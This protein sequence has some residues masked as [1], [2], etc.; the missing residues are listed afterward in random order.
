MHDIPLTSGENQIEIRLSNAWNEPRTLRLKPVTFL[1]PPK[2]TVVKATLIEGGPHVDVS[3][4]VESPE[5]LPIT[6]TRVTVVRPGVD[7][8]VID[9]ADV[10]REGGRWVVTAGQV[11]IE[12]GENAISVQAW[13]R[14]GAARGP[15]PVEKVVFK[16]PPPRKP[17]VELVSPNETT[18]E[19]R[20]SFGVRVQSATRGRIEL[21]RIRRDKP[22]EVLFQT[23]LDD[24]RKVGQGDYVY[25]GTVPVELDEHENYV[26]LRALNE[27]GL[28]LASATVSRIPPPVRV[29][30]DK[31]MSATRK[32]EILT[33]VSL[34]ENRIEFVEG[35]SDG[36]VWLY[37]RVVWGSEEAKRARA[38]KRIQVWVNDFPQVEIP[39]EMPS[40]SG[41][42]ARFR[43]GLL[44]NNKDNHIEVK[45]PG[46][47]RAV[48]DPPTFSVACRNPEQRQRLHLLII[49]VGSE[50]EEELKARALQALRGEMVPGSKVAFK[51]PA[52]RS[53]ILHFTLC[54]DVRI[55]RVLY[56][57]EKI[58]L[59][60]KPLN[61]ATRLPIG[62]EV[63]VIYYQ[64]RIWMDVDD[65]KTVLQLR[66]GG[67]RNNKDVISFE[68]LRNAF[69][70]TRGATLCLLD[71]NGD[72]QVVAQPW[73][74]KDSRTGLLSFM[75]LK[76]PEG[77]SPEIP[78]DAR[79]VK[80]FGDVVPPTFTLTQADAELSREVSRIGQRHPNLRYIRDLP[81]ILSSVVIGS[82]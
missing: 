4:T 57:L 54:K 72:A 29:R 14:D 5:D 61:D 39:L 44:L 32:T 68:H 53:G 41:L 63:V 74:D 45:L 42:E 23:D 16:G 21:V 67:E 25:D 17:I 71:V 82:P 28:G 38:A 1:R 11:P 81:S 79:L 19:A 22:P 31:L 78:D 10:Q 80:V 49:G 7:P 64:G 33:P 13:N 56:Q 60:I 12:R 77:D 65:G 52:F 40:G 36:P 59:E 20:A 58:R 46:V 8:I 51:T 15:A 24:P 6:R 50:T 34:G 66:S 69:A 3:A 18:T 2:V 43:A 76:P 48:G 27:G 26:E 35:V 73:T 55:E 62:T 75:W 30:I 70:G 37:G 47:P 9:D